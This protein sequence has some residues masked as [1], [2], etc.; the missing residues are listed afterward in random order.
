MTTS[1]VAIMQKLITALQPKVLVIEEAGELFEANL[2][3]CLGPQTVH[4]ILIGKHILSYSPHAPAILTSCTGDTALGVWEVETWGS[5]QHKQS[6]SAALDTDHILF[7]HVR[8]SGSWCCAVCCIL[9]VQ[10]T[11]S[12]CAPSRSTTRSKLHPARGTTST[13]APLSAWR[14]L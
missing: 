6:S 12:S 10:A 3:A 4:I 7:S 11:T 8:L 9:L 5:V 13:S 14:G 2:L 1:G